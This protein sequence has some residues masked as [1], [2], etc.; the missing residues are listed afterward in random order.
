MTSCVGI[1]FS[2]LQDVVRRRKSLQDRREINDPGDGIRLV[3]NASLSK[4]AAS[5]ILALFVLA[6]SV[7]RPGPGQRE[8]VRGECR[9]SSMDT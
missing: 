3:L 4:A 5:T 7:P 6:L 1:F 9:S 2:Q 8:I